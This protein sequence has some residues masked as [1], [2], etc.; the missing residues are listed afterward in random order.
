MTIPHVAVNKL[1]RNVKNKIEK[2]I[3][4]IISSG[5]FVSGQEVEQ[6]EK[7][8]S[9]YIQTKY[10]IG[11]STGTDALYLGCKALGI[12][13]GD[14]II[15]PAMSFFATLS[16]IVHLGAKPIFVD[17]LPDSPH[18]DTSQIEKKLSKKTKAIIAVH[19]NG[20]PSDVTEIKRISKKYNLFFIEDACQAHGSTY[21]KKPMGSF[22]DFA[23][24]SFYPSKNLG[25]FGEA[26]AVTTSHASLFKK[27]QLLR[28]HG[29]IK[30]YIH[31][32]YGFNNRLDEIQAAVLNEKLQVLSKENQNR[33]K[34]AQKYLKDLDNSHLQLPVEEKNIVT[35]YH[36][37]VIRTPKRDLLKKYLLSKNIHTG[38]HYPV[39][40]HLQPAV[41]GK[42]GSFKNAE[43]YADECLSLPMYP[44][45]SNGEIE[46]VV[47]HVN[48]FFK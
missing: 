15:L 18:I 39:P 34:I 23:A 19:M 3:A 20:Y 12:K 33:R 2:K 31:S 41:K 45:L 7:L 21:N 25:A 24:F 9:S 4:A 6:F 16:P 29:Q 40:L 37:F 44:S 13:N 47:D 5:Q 14:E 43:K 32:M 1:D 27:I 22:G 8:F 48:K 17:T 38:I 30:K 11:V 46:Y 28:N 42:V 36:N 35:N 10:A 26:G